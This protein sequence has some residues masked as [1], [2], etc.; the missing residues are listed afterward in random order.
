MVKTKKPGK[1]L[2]VLL[3]LVLL[4]SIIPFS[5]FATVGTSTAQYAGLTVQFGD[6]NYLVT[7]PECDMTFS[8]SNG[9]YS[10][11]YE[12]TLSSY[13]PY[14]LA[15]YVTDGNG[16]ITNVTA[17]GM[18][19]RDANNDELILTGTD[20]NATSYL[21]DNGFCTI[22]LAEGSGLTRSLALTTLQGTMTLNFDA[23]QVYVYPNT[24][25]I[26][27]YFDGYLP[28]GQ[29][30]SGA[31]WGSPYSDGNAVNGS[32]PKL[33]ATGFASTGLSLGA[34]GGYAEYDMTINN[35]ARVNDVDVKIQRPYGVDF[36]VYGNAFNGNPEAGSVK[37]FGYLKNEGVE[38]SKWYELAGSL[39]YSDVTLRN[40]SVTYK[41]VTTTDS[42]FTTKGIW[43][44]IDDAD[45]N[46]I[47]G[48][49]KF[50]QTI[51]KIN[52]VDV[53]QDTTVAWWP[54]V[55]EGYLG[56][57]GVYGAVD[58]VIVDTT[59]NTITYQHVTLVKD[60]DTT[61]DY[62]F[63]YFDVTPNPDS[64]AS[65][66]TAI[67]PYA[68]YV[69]GVKG[70]DGYDLDWA[71]DPDGNPVELAA[72]SKIRVYTSAGMKTDGS[73]TFTVPAIFGETSAELCGIFACSATGGGTATAPQ[74]WTLNDSELTISNMGNRTLSAGYYYITSSSSVVLVN[75]VAPSLVSSGKYI[76]SIQNGKSYQIITQNGTESPFVT[77]ITGVSP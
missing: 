1:F 61:T 18:T 59:A 54:E 49:T 4:M 39:Y 3:A 34:A 40:V 36:V 2:A 42:T 20:A 50:N 44:R 8:G 62:T 31:G 24:S 25:P 22:E 57:N 56:T 77:V 67:N 71:V 28:V 74:L 35:Y 7:P 68:T 5:A 6:P 13:Y 15:F 23:P 70:G 72:I 63:G 29:Y 48:W 11:L 60:T 16:A 9:T 45:N 53:Q 17:S 51:K 43:Y 33:L 14:I 32:T 38:D 26:P 73:K 46:Q 27:D 10:V 19:L 76:L 75:G 47:T 30:A 66:G 58:D 64:S 52:G 21:H 65:Y 37:V 41:K 55:S 69:S 12:G